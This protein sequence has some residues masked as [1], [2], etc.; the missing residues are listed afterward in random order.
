VVVAACVLLAGALLSA[1][2]SLTAV[3]D[4]SR[5]TTIEGVVTAFQFVN[6]HPYIEMDVDAAGTQHWR[7]ELDNR[8]ELIAVGMSATT[9]RPGDRLTV[10]GSPARDQGTSMYVRA[11]ERRG[12]G[13]RYEQV[14]TSPRIYAPRR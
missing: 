12:D 10:T 4:G 2:H 6:P 9:I 14:G 5:R 11:F 8:H 1:H 7:L 13:F 3:Y